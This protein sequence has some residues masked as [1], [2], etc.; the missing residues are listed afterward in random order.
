LSVFDA[1]TLRYDL[2]PAPTKWN[3]TQ[4]DGR[5]IEPQGGD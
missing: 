4:C 5:R 2:A 3:S 1:K